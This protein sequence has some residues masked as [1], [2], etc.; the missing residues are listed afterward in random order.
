M[1]KQKPYKGI[2]LEQGIVVRRVCLR[3]TGYDWVG[4]L[5]VGNWMLMNGF[6]F[7]KHIS[8]ASRWKYS[9]EFS[10]LSFNF[11]PGS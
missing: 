10:A 5:G 4:N 11:H 1:I 8:V 3:S 2:R 6:G 9:S 7:R